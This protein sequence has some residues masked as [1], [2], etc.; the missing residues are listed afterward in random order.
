M[1][2]FLAEEIVHTVQSDK[3]HTSIGLQQS[4]QRQLT[5]HGALRSYHGRTQ[6]VS[7]VPIRLQRR[8]E[9]D[10]YTRVHR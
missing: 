1:L 8:W 10:V 6:M 2:P 7:T 3:G 4:V 9:V 5:D